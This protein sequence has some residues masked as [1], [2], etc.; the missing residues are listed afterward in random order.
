[1]PS[2]NKCMIIGNV[3]KEPELRYTPS[4]AAVCNFS[5]AVNSKYKEE[6]HTEWFRITAWQKLAETC[7][8]YLEKG[9]QVYVEGRLQT[10]TWEKGD[11]TT[12]YRTELIANQVIFLGAKGNGGSKETPSPGAPD[13]EGGW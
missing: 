5:V 4:G 6:E 2:L 13:D 1:M 11:G 7:N 12:G 3:G 9:K 10:S 8:Q